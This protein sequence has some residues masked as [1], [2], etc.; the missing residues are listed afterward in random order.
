MQSKH[1][2]GGRIVI[3]VVLLLIG[4]AARAMMYLRENP[5][6]AN[7]TKV[8]PAV[9]NAPPRKHGRAIWLAASQDKYHFRYCGM[10]AQELFRQAVLIAARDSL[11]LQT[12]DA[13][14]REWRGTPPPE[15]TLEM[16]FHGTQIIL[17]EVHDS[18]VVRWHRDYAAV[19]W[20]DDLADL[21][22]I[23]EKMSRD[24]FVTALRKEGWSG[25]GISIK[26]DAPA[27]ADAETRLMDMEELSQFAVLRETYAAV[28]NDGDS[29]QRSGAIVRAYANL[30]QLTRYHWSAEFAVYTARSLLY[31][32]RMVVS[33]PDSAF[34]LWHRAYARAMAGMQGYALKD[35]DAAVRMKG[36]KS[37]DWVALLEPFCQYQTENL[38]NVATAN[39]KLSTLG[40][41]LAFLSAENS[42]SQG[43]TMNI[44][45]AAFT[46]NPQCLRIVDTMCNLTG[47]GMLNDLVNT[48]PNVFRQ[49]LG[50][51]LEKMPAFPQK[52]ID[53][54]TRFKRPGEN[55]GNRGREE[56]CQELIDGGAPALDQVEPSWAALGRLI[57]E[58]T[59]AH[60]QV[61][62]N[63]ICLKWGV[64]AADYVT[65]VEPSIADHPFKFVI[66]TYGLRHS[67]D[68]NTLKRTLE[69]P[70]SVL[71]ESTL[72]ELPIYWLEKEIETDGPISDQNFWQWILVNSDYTSF[73]IEAL[74]LYNEGREKDPWVI[75]QMTHLRRVSP[76][77]PV[78]VAADIRSRWDPIKAATW[79]AEH[80]DYPT[81]AL[82]L[83]K[84]Y[85][86]LQQWTDAE[87]CL[88]K[89]IAVSPDASG[90]EALANV[91]KVQKKDDQ[92]L[93]TLKEFLS[94]GQDY[95][96]QDAGVQVEIAHY[97]MNKRDFKSAVPY[98]DAAAETA[99]GWGLLCAADAHTEVGDWTTAEQLIL[100]EMDH[101]SESPYTWY[102]W[103]SRTGHGDIASARKSLEDYFEGKGNKLDDEDA[104]RF[105]YLQMGQGKNKEALSTWQRRMK[106]WPGPNSALSIA[107][108]DDEMNDAAARDAMLDR[109]Q[110]LPERE[111][112]LGRLALVLRAAIKSGPSSLPEKAAIESVLKHAVGSERIVI[113]A[114]TARFL[115]DRGD[116]AG[117]VEYFKRCIDGRG[118]AD[119]R[120]WVDAELRK[121]GQDPWSLEQAVLP[122][123][124][125]K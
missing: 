41:Y 99:S 92:W 44:A 55:P 118:Y 121:N 123:D 52:L 20:P 13:S 27:P 50:T 22:E 120:L 97:Y 5:P 30:G 8:L 42:G 14:L 74:L 113:C 3:L 36:D 80:G 11:G 9:N 47:P 88:R 10:I 4:I 28:R 94:Q 6:A 87:R 25:S 82:A 23:T 57:Q 51:K 66:D 62:A 109:I 17:H 26:A 33:H 111:K 40:M 102:S 81:V 96:L 7:E 16:D 1:I 69:E 65:S 2:G 21:V 60:V 45:Q 59:F 43:A 112:P 83:G 31:A 85:T 84:K 38:L 86:K 67:A 90:Y 61:M 93:A 114:V 63:L 115:E 122:P 32:Q 56:I 19:R 110:S 34:A 103:C 77:S 18:K 95:G 53:Q 89:Y 72:R 49:T 37:P 64:D 70:N 79:E 39:Q 48:G 58:T 108:I 98:A 76:D 54:I 119:A 107:I 78:L 75:D 100:N 104:A 68:M 105:A 71:Q 106:L 125:W 91:Y 24:D 73:D 101:Y 29:L 35:L 124:A 12:R 15:N 116:T 117:A 46:I